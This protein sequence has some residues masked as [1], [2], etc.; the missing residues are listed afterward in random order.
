[1]RVIRLTTALLGMGIWLMWGCRGLA[2][3]PPVDGEDGGTQPPA[4][5][6]LADAG[7][8]GGG[9]GQD[10]GGAA[11]PDSG[12]L[13]SPDAGAWQALPLRTHAQKGAGM[14][15]GEGFQMIFGMTYAPSNGNVAYM[16]T[17]TSRVWKSVDQGK[18]WTPK[19]R[20]IPS[21]GGISVV[22]SPTDENRVLMAASLHGSWGVSPADGIY[23]TTN[24]G[25]RWRQVQV[26]HF[27]RQRSGT[28]FAFART[29]GLVYAATHD[30]GVLKSTDSGETWVALNVLTA[31]MLSDIEPHPNDPA[32]IYVAAPS[33]LF[34]V[35][36]QNPA[37]A[38]KVGAGLSASPVDIM[39]APTNPPTLYVSANNRGVFKSIN[40]GDSFVPKNAGLE[41]VLLASTSIQ[42][43][44]L[45]M[46]PKN[47]Q[48]LYASI[49][50]LALLRQPFYSDDGGEHWHEAEQMD[51]NGL[52]A[53][54]STWTTNR[55]LNVGSP[56]ATHPS[57]EEVAL[58]LGEPDRPVITADSGKTWRYSGNG[59]TGG[60]PRFG[61]HSIGWNDLSRFAVFL[62]DYGV[63]LTEDAGDTFR[64]IKLPDYKQR[65]DSGIG[66]A[67]PTPGSKVM[68]A[69]LGEFVTGGQLVPAITQDG[70]T[71]TLLERDAAGNSMED[72]YQ[73]STV[74]FNRQNPNTVYLKRF[75]SMDKG[76]TW[77]RLARDVNAVFPGNGGIVYS[78]GSD[79]LGCTVFK[80]TDSGS[81]WSQP[82]GH[83]SPCSF[84]TMAVDPGD[85]SRLY[86][87]SR[88][89]GVYVYDGARWALKAEGQ[90]LAKDHFGQFSLMLVAA[91]PRPA[92]TTVYAAGFAA[93][94][95]HSNGV[96]RSTDRGASWVNISD[97]LG[98]EFNVN[99]IQVN[100]WNGR[101]FIGSFAGTWWR[102]PPSL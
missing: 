20:G 41:A 67:D 93:S 78:R 85:Q 82:M 2:E 61:N 55:G 7:R 94:I 1:M 95:G 17:D 90:G 72:D 102:A 49:R 58:T 60:A 4:A 33:G 88:H 43:T 50:G 27:R 8:D 53:D 40:G 74:A 83:F 99:S 39:V 57:A 46:S 44:Y 13:P 15:G 36:A 65:G 59:Y 80:S 23:L 32:V 12:I 9:S 35:T 45:G 96:F 54:L 16:V 76:R 48:R 21:N 77:T 19:S 89:Q 28:H 6:Y 11:S 98:S 68:V 29:P 3:L 10:A 42:V 34:R 86:V 30:L 71:W 52:F 81:T 26:A 73:F 25:E 5:S 91:D 47:R 22:V 92:S 79:A 38:Q 101:V 18:S 100:P 14:S 51:S 63:F 56:I 66:A 84:G 64:V 87:A 24:G 31:Q 69:I 75:R 62:D 70:T 37:M 97:N